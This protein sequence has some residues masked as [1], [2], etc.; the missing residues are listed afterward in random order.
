MQIVEEAQLC[1]EVPLNQREVAKQCG[2]Y[3][4]D[5]RSQHALMWHSVE[6]LFSLALFKS[7]SHQSQGASRLSTSAFSLISRRGE[8][9]L[10]NVI[11]EAEYLLLNIEA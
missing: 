4:P 1:W 10:R 5:Q 11:K 9:K 2:L 3:S 8:D 6:T 7:I